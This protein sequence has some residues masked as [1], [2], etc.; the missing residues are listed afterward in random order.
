MP[1]EAYAYSSHHRSLEFL[2]VLSVRTVK[3]MGQVSAAAFW[4]ASNDYTLS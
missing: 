4:Y 2:I 3:T 1:V